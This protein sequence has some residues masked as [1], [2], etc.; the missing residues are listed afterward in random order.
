ADGRAR[1]ECARC[2]LGAGNRAVALGDPHPAMDVLQDDVAL[3]PG[4]D[5]ENQTRG[6]TPHR[7]A[8]EGHRGVTRARELDLDADRVSIC[9]ADGDTATDTLSPRLTQSLDRDAAEVV[10]RGRG[11]RDCNRDG[12]ALARVRC[13]NDYPA[14]QSEPGRGAGEGRV[15]LCVRGAE[16]VGGDRVD[17]IDANGDRAPRG[18]DDLERSGVDGMTRSRS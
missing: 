15:R 3:V 10:A 9:L 13:D 12:N 6:L 17:R 11:S 18:I 14:R 5:V 2:N 4:V 1:D 7:G 16:G 8:V